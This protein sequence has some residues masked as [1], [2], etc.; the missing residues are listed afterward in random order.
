MELRSSHIAIAEIDS[1][2]ALLQL[3]L[4]RQQRLLAMGISWGALSVLLIV[5]QWLILAY[6]CEQ[7][8]INAIAVEQQIHIVG[9]LI[10]LAVSRPFFS[11]QQ[12]ITT[13]KAS[14]L[15][16][17]DLRETLLTEW[18]LAN[19]FSLAQYSEGKLATMWLEDIE[20]M[21]GFVAKYYPQQV[22][23]I[24]GPFFILATVFYLNW[25]CGLFLLV[26]A[27]LIP[28]FM[29]LVGMGAEH[30]NQKYSLLR[31]RLSGHF[32]DR[33]SKLGSIKH[34]N[35]SAQIRTEVEQQ[36][37]AYRSVIMQTLKLAFLS[38][39]V[40]EFFS[41]VAIA[42]IA[43]YIGFAL[44]GAISWGPAESLTLFSGLAILFLA[45]DFFKPL[46]NLSAYYHDKAGA[47]GAANNIVAQHKELHKKP[48]CCTQQ[49]QTIDRQCVLYIEELLIGINQQAINTVPLNVTIEQ[50]SLVV[51]SGFSG[52]G[53]T[54]LLNTLTGFL[55]PISGSVRLLCSKEA[56]IA[57]LP[58]KP[59]IINASIREN[60]L[61]LAPKAN[62]QDM[63]QVL[64]Q[65]HLKNEIMDKRQ[66]LNTLLG[67]H[68]QGLSGGQM[69]RIALAR[70]LLASYPL[71][72]LDEPTAKLDQL[73]RE[74]IIDT[75]KQ[76]KTSSIVVVASHDNLLMQ[77]A[78]L[79]IDLATQKA[80]L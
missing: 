64:Q 52:A 75:L 65:L 68:G 42:A 16:R 6:L 62:D 29:V 11:K 31:Q 8:L 26:S 79:H 44:Y 34:L 7:V 33:L 22:L 43:I 18:R 38:S 49:T 24:L 54:T 47:L 9:L 55:P 70:C 67:E 5:L 13:Q 76:L 53:K 72:V 46:R 61:A 2:K 1:G 15:L 56:G 73:S 58:Q 25:L 10:I 39:A 74:I 32:L 45:P 80:P 71:V 17:Q 30:I 37:H 69:Q 40:L 35:A 20:A 78:D 14:Q 36:G 27:P 59:W 57:Y 77:Q 48:L 63:L 21:D 3:L 19:P 41:S 51:V 66:G 4:S 28:L 23:A 60:L 12:S 50:N